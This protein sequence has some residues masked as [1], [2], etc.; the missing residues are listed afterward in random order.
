[1]ET[2]FILMLL[3][4]T[5]LTVCNLA[6]GDRDYY[7]YYWCGQSTDNC[8]KSCVLDGCA[9]GF[10]I[11]KDCG[12]EKVLDKYYYRCDTLFCTCRGCPNGKHMPDNRTTRRD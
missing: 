2:K 12:E 8:N 5:F 6:K 9:S 1:M 3:L 11:R 10:C 4:A 7:E